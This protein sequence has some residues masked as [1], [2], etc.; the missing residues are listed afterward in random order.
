[1]K[2][3]RLI[4]VLLTVGLLA[5]C[6]TGCFKQTRP[7]ALFRATQSEETVPFSV[8][9]DGTLSFVPEGSIVSYLWTFGDGA[10]DSGPLVEH[11]YSE[12]G[13]YKA[14]LTI[15]D[16]TGASTSTAM[17][18]H[19]LNPP[20][21]AGFT[22][23]PQS[24]MDGTPI[25]SCSETITFSASDILTGESL[26]DD[27]GEI[28]W[29]HWYFGYRDDNNEPVISEGPW[30]THSVVQHKYMY[31]WDYKVILTVTDNDGA[32]GEYME[33]IHV[34]GGPPCNADVDDGTGGG[35]C[36]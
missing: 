34:E 2:M 21:T 22:Y 11:T 31:S 14:E 9:F 15:I 28:V 3:T 25:V 27:D 30:E 33:I 26:C 6:L 5:V 20:P 32:T 1:M 24:N 29:C 19:A 16:E 7:Q 23:A 35:T 8:S 4:L 13:T 17:T 18:I 12:N 10:T 36:G